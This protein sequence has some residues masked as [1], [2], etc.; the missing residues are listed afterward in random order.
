MPADAAQF[1]VHPI[2]HVEDEC[3]DRMREVRDL[4]CGEI[5]REIFD[6]ADG[7]GVSALAVEEFEL[8]ALRHS[9]SGPR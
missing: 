3:G 5:G 7:V 6:A 1:I 4:L 9:E 2:I 8:G